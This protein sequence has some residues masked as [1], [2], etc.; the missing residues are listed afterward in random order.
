MRKKNRSIKL[1]MA[2]PALSPTFGGVSAVAAPVQ[3]QTADK[4]VN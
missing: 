4:C 1:L 2:S 3:A